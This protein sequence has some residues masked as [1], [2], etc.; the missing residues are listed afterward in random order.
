MKLSTKGRYGAR[1]LM[2]LAKHHGNGPVPLNKIAAQQ[3][4]PL[5]YLEQLV[6][7]LKAA[8]MIKS[9]RGPSGGYILS[10]PPEK[11]NLLTLIET[12]EGPLSF[13]DCVKDPSV[14]EKVDAC[15]F[16]DLWNRIN[17]EIARILR[18]VT[19]ADM[20]KADAKKQD[21]L[22]DCRGQKENLENNSR[23]QMEDNGG[24]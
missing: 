13:V 10:K 1:A 2:E 9:V 17:R 21:Q 16:S 18:G 19:I 23:Q 11:I 4:I 5:K 22:S 8:K 24:G 15:A 14:C 6:S 7:V 12:L 3:D 20:V